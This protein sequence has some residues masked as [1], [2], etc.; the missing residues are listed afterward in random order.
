MLFIDRPHHFVLHA[1]IGR[2]GQARFK[3]GDAVLLAR[4]IQS[5]PFNHLDVPAQAVRAPAL[6][7]IV[8]RQR[9]MLDKRPA[10]HARNRHS[11]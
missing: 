5:L 9:K 8:Y 3:D 2:G 10:C 1:G 7:F 4:V 6:S 11:C